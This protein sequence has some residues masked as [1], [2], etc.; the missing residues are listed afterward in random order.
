M[1]PV[2]QDGQLDIRH[3]LKTS[4]TKETQRNRKQVNTKPSVPTSNVAAEQE[5]E[6]VHKEAQENVQKNSRKYFHSKPNVTARSL[7]KKRR[8][9]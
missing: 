5:T 3:T 6:K 2:E 9:S 4:S 1:S 8:K 7:G